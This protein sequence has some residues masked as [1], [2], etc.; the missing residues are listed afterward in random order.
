MGLSTGGF[1]YKGSEVSDKYVLGEEGRGFYRCMEGF[2][3]ARAV[4][5]SACLGGA[6]KCLDISTEYVKQRTAFGKPIGQFE[7]ILFEMAEDWTRLEAA[8]LM[9]QKGCFMI[10]KFYS[11]PGSFTQAEINPV[12]AYNKWL[13]PLIGADMAR[14]AMMYHG[15]F[16]YTKDSPLEMAYRGVLSYVVGAE[17]APNI[18]KIIIGRDIFGI[19]GAG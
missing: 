13:A 19:R 4:V 7:G 15:A 3:V 6:E 9:L 16:G 12:I 10:D 17:G 2:N 8:K 18:M 5:S 11:E 14:H 1:I